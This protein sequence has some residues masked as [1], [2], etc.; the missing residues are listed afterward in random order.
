MILAILQRFRTLKIG[1][2]TVK[3][4]IVRCIQP[5]SLK[6]TSCTCSDL[7]ALGPTLFDMSMQLNNNNSEMTIAIKAELL[8]HEVFYSNL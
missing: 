8:K 6:Q 4:Q 7:F 3:L 2:K 5:F 1:E